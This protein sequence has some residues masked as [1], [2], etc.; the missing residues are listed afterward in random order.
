MKSVDSA[1]I[2]VTAPETLKIQ[3]NVYGKSL[4]FTD[5]IGLPRQA[6]ASVSVARV[7]TTRS[8]R[9]RSLGQ[10][11]LC[12]G[13]SDAIATGKPECSLCAFSN[14]SQMLRYDS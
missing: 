8:A 14:H 7:S 10:R 2:Q 11:L 9:R 13:G 4:K 3:T 12:R 5:P 6:R 1:N